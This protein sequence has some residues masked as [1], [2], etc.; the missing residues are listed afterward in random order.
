M[1]PYYASKPK[2][3]KPDRAVTLDVILI[4]STDHP[5]YDIV[6]NNTTELARQIEK[7]QPSILALLD[8][9]I[10]ERAE[11]SHWMSRKS[12][13]DLSKLSNEKHIYYIE[14]LSEVRIIL[15]ERMETGIE[16]SSLAESRS[17]A[18]TT[19]LPIQKH[20]ATLGKRKTSNTSLQGRDR[21]KAVKHSMA[22]QNQ[23]QEQL[24]KVVSDSCEKMADKSCA[25][26]A[27]KPM[28]YASALRV[29]VAA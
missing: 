15:R 2:V 12:T 13:D 25:P 18:K 29:A 3:S 10:L 22:T 11:Y 9:L 23:Q 27:A 16:T 6:V 5:K 17:P 21:T 20:N 8:R 14:I 26:V 7:V 1:L 4:R 24:R 28:S 19:R